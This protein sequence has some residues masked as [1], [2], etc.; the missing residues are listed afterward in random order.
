[1]AKSYYTSLSDINLAKEVI[2]KTPDLYIQKREFGGTGTYYTDTGSNSGIEVATSP[3]WTNNEFASTVANNILILDDNNK[4]ATG[5]ITGNTDDTAFFDPAALVLEEDGTTAPTFSAGSTYQ[6]RIYSPSSV[7][8]ATYGPFF[9]LVE[10]SELNINDTFMKFKYSR[11]KQMKFKDLEERE[12]IVT[13]GNVNFTNDDVITTMFGAVPYG[14]QTG[15]YSYAIG[16]NPDTDLFYRPTFIGEDRSNRV[17]VVRLREVQFEITGNIFQNAESGHHM[18]P[19][20]ADL[21][22]DGFYPEDANM[23]QVI[24]I[25]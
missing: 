22:A 9:G 11:P 2:A 8:G 1:M 23:L 7:A 17:F 3:S 14:S 19:F 5:K 6:F 13:G 10:G 4:V 12:G 24:R 18:A 20:T 25:D 16:S 21:I 15:Q